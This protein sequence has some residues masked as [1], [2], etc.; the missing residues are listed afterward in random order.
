MLCVTGPISSLV[1][2]FLVQFD[3]SGIGLEAARIA[4]VVG[5][6][7]FCMVS[8]TQSREFLVEAFGFDSSH[9]II[10]DEVSYLTDL[11][12]CVV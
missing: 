11:L 6:E 10:L 8:T 7:V 3:S 9:V 5:S 4:E 2:L 12:L 1:K